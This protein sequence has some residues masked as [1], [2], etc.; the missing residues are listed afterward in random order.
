MCNASAVGTENFSN[1]CHPW[2]TRGFQV[3]FACL[4]NMTVNKL[5]VSYFVRNVVFT[6]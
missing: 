5:T 3:Y 2:C 1:G 4:E 6:L